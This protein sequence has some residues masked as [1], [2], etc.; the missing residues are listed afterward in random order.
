[1]YNNYR[2]LALIPARGGSKG[3]PRKNI[4]EAGGKP[5]LAWTIE[6]AQDSRYIDRL[7]LSSEDREIIDAAKRWGCE[8]PFV[9]PREL[10]EDDTPAIEAI[11][12]AMRKMPHYD[13]IMLLQ[14]TSPLRNAADIDACI[15][16]CLNLAANACVSVSEPDKS[17]YW[18]FF[19]D[20]QG[21]LQPLLQANKKLIARRQDLPKVYSLNGAIYLARWE[22]L[23]EHKTFVHDDTLAYPMPKERSLDIDSKNDFLLFKALTG[24]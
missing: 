21:H 20:K 5:L 11:L 3:L 24:A 10:A 19:L 14:A 23:L 8:V 15:E 17:P 16:N 4:L 18:M 2:I 22:W 9:R 12:H 13:Y 7:I 6:A 1:M